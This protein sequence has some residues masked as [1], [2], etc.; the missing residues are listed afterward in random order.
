MNLWH[1]NMKLRIV[2]TALVA[3]QTLL[4]IALMILRERRDVYQNP[5]PRIINEDRYRKPPK[6]EVNE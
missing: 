4:K 1:F 5:P 2:L 6:S 3:T